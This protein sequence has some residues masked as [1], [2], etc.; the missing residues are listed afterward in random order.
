[1]QINSLQADYVLISQKL[2]FKTL[3]IIGLLQVKL[4]VKFHGIKLYEINVVKYLGITTGNKLRWSHLIIY[5]WF[6]L[7][8]ANTIT[9]KVWNCLDMKTYNLPIILITKLY[10]VCMLQ[11]KCLLLMHFLKRFSMVPINEGSKKDSTW[12]LI[13]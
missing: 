12:K 11:K 9:P 2:N 8:K 5:E 4:K 10:I 13:V 3:E 6:K 1:M 7:N